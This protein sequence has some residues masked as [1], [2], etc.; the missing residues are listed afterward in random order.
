MKGRRKELIK[1]ELHT[2][3]KKGFG[4]KSIHS[5]YGMTELL[6]QAYS[7]G[8]GMFLKAPEGAKKRKLTHWK[9]KILIFLWKNELFVEQRKVCWRAWEC[10]IL[11]FPKENECF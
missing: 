1:S 7:K 11:F 5:E 3:L 9:R 10:K 2:L 6:S 4:V 8:D